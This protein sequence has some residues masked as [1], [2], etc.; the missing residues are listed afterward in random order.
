M[1]TK[2][3]SE[4]TDADRELFD[5]DL[6]S[7][8]PSRVFDAHAHLYDRRYFGNLKS[9]I[10]GHGPDVVGL[11]IFRAEMAQ[12]LPGRQVSGLFM[13]YPTPELNF[14]R[15]NT[16]LMEQVK[17]DGQSRALMV[18]NPQMDPD[19][20]REQVT[21]K[22]FVGLKCYHYYSAE[23]PT[24]NATLP[25]FLPEEQVRVAHEQGLAITIHIVRARA[26][27]DPANQTVLRNYAQRY[28]NARFILAHA[29]RGFNPH[30]T[31]RGIGALRGLRNIW[32]DTSAI[33]ECGA[34]EAIVQVLGKDRLLY[35]SDYPMFVIRG[36]AV[37]IGDSFL[38]LDETN[39]KFQADYAKIEPTLIGY[40]SLRALKIACLNLGLR[41]KDVEGIFWGNAA[42]LLSLR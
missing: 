9:W 16:F 7:F 42:K 33:C 12:L 27:Y 13:G 3:W 8:V 21:R 39:T 36:R 23:R 2:S 28:P 1:P 34:L 30:H 15:T 26:L 32:C 40:E 25:S 4:I 17:L 6:K 14:D 37:A 10:M 31:I 24:F 35:G 29:A 20:I 18:V 41:G 11:E 22:G 38:W 19:F 5:L